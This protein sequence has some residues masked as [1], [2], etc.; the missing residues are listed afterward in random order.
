M[1]DIFCARIKVVKVV[2][3]VV[4]NFEVFRDSAPLWINL[5]TLYKTLI[6]LQ[7]TETHKV[8]LQSST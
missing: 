8:C 2:F 3:G 5:E 7:V 4:L 1:C 6:S